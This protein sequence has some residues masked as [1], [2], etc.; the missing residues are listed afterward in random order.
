MATGPV[1][2]FYLLTTGFVCCNVISNNVNVA[3]LNRARDDNNDVSGIDMFDDGYCRRCICR[4]RDCPQGLFGRC[5]IGGP[6]CCCCM[7]QNYPCLNMDEYMRAP[8]GSEADSLEALEEGLED[9]GRM[10]KK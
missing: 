2:A 3:T 4:L 10:E 1:I 6:L 8:T 7:P 9:I 5:L